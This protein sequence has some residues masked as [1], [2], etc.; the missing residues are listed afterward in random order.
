MGPYAGVDYNLTLCPLHS[1]LKHIYQGQS[2]VD[3]N[4]MLEST[5]S[6]SQGL[7]IWPLLITSF[8][9]YVCHFGSQIPDLHSAF[10]KAPRNSCSG[11]SP[12]SSRFY[13]G[14]KIFFYVFRQDLP[15]CDK[16]REARRLSGQNRPSC[17]SH[18]R[19]HSG[20]YI[21]FFFICLFFVESW[22]R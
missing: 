18:H 12:S 21:G 22:R 14:Y 3:R 11:S 2:K 7:W 19:C 1:R 13:T 8:V 20:H 4:P 17:S 9:L 16:Q 5:L 6:P 10:K 15:A